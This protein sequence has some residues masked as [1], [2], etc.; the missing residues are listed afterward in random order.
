MNNKGITYLAISILLG[1][2]AV[3][4]AAGH[5]QKGDSILNLKIE[6]ESATGKSLRDYYTAAPAT[7]HFADKS[8]ISTAR[9]T[10]DIEKFD[11]PVVVQNGDGHNLY[12]LEAESYYKLSGISTVWG[13]AGYHNGKTRDIAFSDVIGYETVAPFVIGDDTGGDLSSQQYD[14]GGGWGRTFGQWAIGLQGDYTAAIAH[15][16]VDP[17]VRNIVSDLNVTIGGARSIGP[18]YIIGLN[19][20]VSIYHQDTDVDFYNPVTHAITM[21]YTGLGS[22]ASR[23]K[24]ADAQSTTHRMTGFNATLQFVP[25]THSDRFYATLSGKMTRADLILDGYNNLNFG[26]TSTVSVDGR[27]SRLVTSGPV[28]FFPTLSGHYVNR[29]ATEN[30]FGSSA[31]NYEKIGQRENY[32]HNRYGAALDIPVSWRLKSHQTLLTLDLS[33]GYYNDKEYLIEPSRR[34]ETNYFTGSL[35][36]DV[37]KKIGGN[38]AV[39]LRLGY[40]GRFVGSTSAEWA[41]LDLTSPEGE[42]TLHN[43]NLSSCNANAQHAGLVISRPIKTMVVSLSARYTRYD[44]NDFNKGHRVFTALSLSF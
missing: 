8:S 5:P 30:L 36:L 39:G 33:G 27:L 4:L 17:R 21:V 1:I 23:F 37:T 10:A 35:T 26:T 7:M 12:G 14:F 11:V 19:C 6:R 40:D 13:H 43:Y 20:G 15:R 31:G 18:A 41:G 3:S 9:V 42:M 32:N 24:G 38:W 25:T 34:V 28:S 2:P 16:A 22:T 29:A 44:Y